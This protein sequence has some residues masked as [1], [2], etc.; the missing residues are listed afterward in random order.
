MRVA[1]R[2]DTEA[3][4]PVLSTLDKGALP[5]GGPGAQLMAAASRLRQGGWFEIVHEES[6]AESERRPQIGHER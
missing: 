1:C 4:T 3:S 2:F 6:G 5:L